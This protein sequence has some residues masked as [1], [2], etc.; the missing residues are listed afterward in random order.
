MK[1]QLWICFHHQ[2]EH[3]GEQLQHPTK[4]QSREGSSPLSSQNPKSITRIPGDG[5][6]LPPWDYLLPAE[7]KFFCHILDAQMLIVTKFET[8]RARSCLAESWELNAFVYS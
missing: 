7:K 5:E 8:G 3:S 4:Q 2:S 1:S 6:E